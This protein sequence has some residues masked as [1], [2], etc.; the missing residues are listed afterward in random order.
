MRTLSLQI[1]H[2][3]GYG[4]IRGNPYQHMHVISVNRPCVNSQLF[5]D[6]YLSQ[7]LT[8]SIPNISFQHWISILCRPYNVVFTIPYCMSAT[9]ILFH[10]LK[11]TTSRPPKGVG[12]TDPLSGDSKTQPLLLNAQ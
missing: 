2:R 9:L 11:S 3:L 1:L 8:T 7:Q 6:R 10:T 4:H 12:F 5:T